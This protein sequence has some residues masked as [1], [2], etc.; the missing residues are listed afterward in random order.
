MEKVFETYVARNLKQILSN[1]IWEVSIQD[2]G[3]YLFNSPKRFA[4]RLDIVIKRKDSSRVLLDTKWKM[5]IDNQ[6][7]NHGIS[8]VD[9][10]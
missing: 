7:R 1:L 8:Q 10:Y 9:T 4:L 3:R 2:K 5:L 6:N